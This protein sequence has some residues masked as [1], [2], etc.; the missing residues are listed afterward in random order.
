MAA[1]GKGLQYCRLLF[2]ATALL[3]PIST[4]TAILIFLWAKWPNGTIRFDNP[5]AKV[6]VLY[7]DGR[8]NFTEQI[9]MTGQGVHESTA[10]DLN[11]DGKIDILGKPFIHNIP[12][13]DVWLN[14]SLTG[15][16]NHNGSVNTSD[17]SL[18]PCTGRL[19]IAADFAGAAAPT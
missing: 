12:R 17:F 14:N 16:I 9:V 11:G 8:G 2:T 10:A 7:G 18:W 19:P 15:D 3:W 13:L 4:A 1:T 5:N 6:R